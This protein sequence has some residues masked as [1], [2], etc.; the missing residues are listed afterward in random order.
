MMGGKIDKNLTKTTEG[1]LSYPMAEQDVDLDKLTMSPDDRDFLS[2]NERAAEIFAMK[3][4]WMRL[5]KL[6]SEVQSRVIG[7]MVSDIRL[8]Y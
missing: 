2:R 7:M 1:L 6:S 4:R 5:E 3:A 8:R